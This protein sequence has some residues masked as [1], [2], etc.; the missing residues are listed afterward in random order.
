MNLAWAMSLATMIFPVKES[1]VD[2]G[3][4]VSSARTSSMGRFRSISTAGAISGS[5]A[6]RYSAGFSTSCS[7]NTPSRVILPLI[8]RSAE[9]ETPMPTGQD[10]PWRGSLTIRISRAK[11]LPPNCA[12][13]PKSL[14]RSRTFCSRSMSLNAWPVS[15]PLVGRVS[16]YLADA[17]FTALRLSSAE[18]PPMTNAM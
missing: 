17:S 14:D 8:C 16:R 4:L 1:R 9:Q 6:G 10:A 15:L 12:P 13:S 7:R 2:T 11:Y 5:L 18:V 3:Y